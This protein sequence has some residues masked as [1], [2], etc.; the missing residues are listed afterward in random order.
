MTRLPEWKKTTISEPA[1]LG[2]PEDFFVHLYAAAGRQF[3]W[4]KEEVSPFGILIA[5]ILLKQTQADK[6]ANVW[7]LLIARYSDVSQLAMARADELYGMIA[8]LGFGRQRTKAL[9]D[10]A[11]SITQTGDLPS[12][13]EDLIKLPYVGVYTAHAVACFAFGQ[14]VPVVDLSIVRTFS[15]VVGIETP[16]DIRRA[17]S[18]WNFAWSLLPRDC[19]KEHNYGVLDFAALFCKPRSP[20]CGECPLVTE[21]AYA[22][23]GATR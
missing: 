10:V 21:C 3:P 4:R 1:K 12:E 18:I 22:R 17:K 20:N 16:T 19:F 13:T 8:V 9:I 23:N 2:I 6:V 11:D 7:P 5:E 14:R 15:R